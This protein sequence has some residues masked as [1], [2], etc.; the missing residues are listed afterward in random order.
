MSYTVH[1]PTR[2]ERGKLT[3]LECGITF[4]R[5]AAELRGEQSR[6]KYCSRECSN[7]KPTKGLHAL[8][9]KNIDW[10]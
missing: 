3:C 10:K 2:V 9:F 5:T 1:R 7:K 6:G 4:E 8:G